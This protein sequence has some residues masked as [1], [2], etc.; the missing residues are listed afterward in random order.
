MLHF[1][2]LGDNYSI[3]AIVGNINVKG[4]IPTTTLNKTS[5]AVK[6]TY[7]ITKRLTFAANVNFFDT[8]ISGEFDDALF[9]PDNRFFQPV[10]PQGP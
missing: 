10:V 5:F 2:K 9:K 8:K 1:P 3:R 7:D 4:N 6:T